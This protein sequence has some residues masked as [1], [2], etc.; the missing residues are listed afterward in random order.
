MA[1]PG[2][3]PIASERRLVGRRQFREA[4]P[5]SFSI[6]IAGSVSATVMALDTTA[7][8]NGAVT[9]DR[10]HPAKRT[11]NPAAACQRRRRGAEQ[12]LRQ[13]GQRR[14]RDEPP[15]RPDTTAVA[16][17]GSMAI[18]VLKM[19]RPPRSRPPPSA[20]PATSRSARWRPASNATSASASPG[21]GV[22][23]AKLECR[24][25]LGLD[26]PRDRQR[27]CV[28]GNST[29]TGVSGGS[30]RDVVAQAYQTT[31]VGVGAGALYAGV[32]GGVGVSIPI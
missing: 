7:T 2:P 18:G 28:D 21:R 22:G 5:P 31:D 10:Y 20:T 26:R 3:H 4:T 6:D 16:V 14:G 9:I 11:G 24:F 17:A 19:R 8:V 29:I 30:G 23:R 13:G 32:K 15:G 1:T 25:G 12:H 27:Q